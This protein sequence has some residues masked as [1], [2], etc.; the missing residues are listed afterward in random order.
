MFIEA[1]KL[2]NLPVASYDTEAKVGAIRQIIVDPE[3]GKVLGFMVK[4][5]RLLGP[6]L[7]LSIIDVAEWDPNGLVTTSIEN[8]IPPKEIIH[9]NEVYLKEINLFQMAAKTEGGKK[10]GV[11]EDFLIDTDTQ[12]VAKYYLK[13]LFGKSLVLPSDKVVKIDKQ[14]IFSDDVGEM[15][16]GVQGATT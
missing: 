8:L 12:T 14:I 6:T 7:A 13:D 4:T 10:L 2:T 15:P 1:K 16:T 11:V 9:F 5:M 3:N